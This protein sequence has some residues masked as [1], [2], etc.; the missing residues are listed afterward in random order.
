MSVYWRELPLLKLVISDTMVETAECRANLAGTASGIPLAQTRGHMSTTATH[1]PYCALQC[2]MHLTSENGAVV[3]HGNARF[4]VNRGGLCV[5]GWTAAAT[6]AHADRLREP[7]VRGANG[8]L[9]PASWD[10]ALNR[11]AD[12]FHR[13]QTRYGNDAVAIFGSG[14]QFGGA[15]SVMR[16][17]YPAVS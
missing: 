6:L 11:V 4:P 17:Y 16:L 9:G 1:C 7:L 5:K 8:Q 2:G 13:I 10:A 3:V 15:G 12:A 14:A